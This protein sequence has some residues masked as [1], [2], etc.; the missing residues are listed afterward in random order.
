MNSSP[1]T[2]ATRSAG[3]H[4]LL[5]A[6]AHLGQHLV[7]EIVAQGVVDFLETV[8]VQDQHHAAVAAAI[9][10]P[11]RGLQAFARQVAV[12]QS[13]QRIVV[14]LVTDAFLA[15]GDLALHVAESSRQFGDFVATSHRHR[16]RIIARTARAWPRPPA[17]RAA[18][19]G[20]APAIRPA[21]VRSRPRP[22]RAPGCGTS[23]HGTA[24]SPNP[25]TPAAAGS[26]SPLSESGSATA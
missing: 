8:Q 12:R 24:P 20:C 2:R 5:Q 14:G 13:G 4:A 22:P 25:S 15:R 17:G 19:S 26:R 21:P 7:G 16:L 18:G 1:P 23:T 11:E 3:L 9:A 6:Y 10:A